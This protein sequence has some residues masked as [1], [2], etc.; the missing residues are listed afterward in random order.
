MPSITIKIDAG[1]VVIAVLFL[2]IGYFLGN[3]FQL[4]TTQIQPAIT[5][6]II[7]PSPSQDSSLPQQPSKVQVSIEDEPS[8]GKKDAKVVIVEFN[9]FQCPFCK[10]HNDQTY[11]QIKKE[12][13]DTGKVLLVHKSFPLP[14]HTEADEADEAA[15]CAFEQGKYWEM[16]DIIFA[17]QNDWAGNSK[18]FDLFKQYATQIPGLD[19]NKFNSCVDSAKYRNEVQGDIQEGGTA[20]VSGTPTFFV[21]G[22]EVVGAQPY[23]VFQQVIDAELAA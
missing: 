7:A 8:L 11:P 3:V 5:G 2:V 19:A 6:Q 16:H 20:G 18:P 13:I 9:D 23:S 15:A 1:T 21:N 14:F 4:G 12:Y 22:L 10:R 17:K